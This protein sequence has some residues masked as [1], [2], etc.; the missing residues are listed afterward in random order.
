MTRHTLCSKHT[1]AHRRPRASPPPYG[2]ALAFQA[3]D[4][5]TEE[6]SVSVTV[7][8]AGQADAIKALEALSRPAAGLAFDG[9]YASISISKLDEDDD[10]DSDDNRHAD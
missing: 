1:Y 7:I 2:E 10:D 6:I 8:C 3:E 5:V 4:A 9:I